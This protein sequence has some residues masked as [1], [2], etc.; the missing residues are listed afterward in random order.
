MDELFRDYLMG[1][2]IQLFVITVM[3]GLIALL[4]IGR[5]RGYTMEITSVNGEGRRA[6]VEIIK[7]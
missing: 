1:I 2:M 6:G 7:A 5:R 3:L 4:L